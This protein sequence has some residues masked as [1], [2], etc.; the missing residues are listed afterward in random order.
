MKKI[1]VAFLLAMS[2][3]TTPQIKAQ[4]FFDTSQ[5][6]YWFTFSGRIGFNTSNRTFPGGYYN[7]WNNN[8]WGTGFNI[9]A[10]GNLNIREYLSIQPGIFF[11]SRSGDYAYLTEYLDY[12][13]KE[14]THYEMGHLR[15]YYIT[16]PVMGV[17]KFNISPKVQWSVELGPYYQ[18][19]LSETGQNNVSIIYR[20]PNSNEY[21][22]YTAEHKKMDVGIKV[23]SGLKIFDHYYL[24]FHYLGGF[25][26]AWKLPAGG[27]NKS[28]QFSLGYDF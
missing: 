25:M 23:G 22:E 15:A 12:L 5:P 18:L 6:L 27:R 21:G 19:Y 17:V 20:L 26:D 14:Q 1:I 24:G 4:S 2:F 28:W 13:N 3:I 8:S 16:V 11:E 10:L 9:G 7:L